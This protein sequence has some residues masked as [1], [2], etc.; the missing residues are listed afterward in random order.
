MELDTV[1]ESNKENLPSEKFMKG[2][3]KPFRKPLTSERKKFA[4][5][6]PC[7]EWKENKDLYDVSDN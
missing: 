1:D 7:I 3:D 6:D 2:N 4:A 5:I